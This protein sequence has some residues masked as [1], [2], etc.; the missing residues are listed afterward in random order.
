MNNVDLSVCFFKK[1]TLGQEG[2]VNFNRKPQVGSKLALATS[3]FDPGQ[4]V[5]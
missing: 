5:I 4:V 1:L 2:A 3:L